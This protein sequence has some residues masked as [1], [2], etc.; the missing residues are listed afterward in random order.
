MGQ[1]K[2]LIIEQEK[3]W[4]PILNWAGKEFS[5]ELKYTHSLSIDDVQPISEAKLKIFFEKLSD[6]EL[7]SFYFA[8]LKMRSLLLAAAFIKGAINAEEAYNASY[9]E[10][11]YQAKLWGIDVESEA[12]RLETLKQL[13]EIELFL[14]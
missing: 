5:E 6:K 3:I 1:E 8:A 13:K 14:K 9:V 7:A 12:V 10:E 4:E 2:E 11:V